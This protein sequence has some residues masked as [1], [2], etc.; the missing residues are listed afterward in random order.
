MADQEGVE[1]QESIVDVE[2]IDEKIPFTAPEESEMLAEHEALTIKLEEQASDTES[3]TESNGNSNDANTGKTGKGRSSNWR[4]G[5]KTKLGYRCTNYLKEDHKQPLFGVTFNYNFDENAED[6]LIF[7]TVGSNRASIYQ[8]KDKG[9][10]KLLQAYVDADPDE[11]FYTAA[12]S[13][14]L[15]SGEPILA[16]AGSRGIIRI[17]SAFTMQCS[18]HFLGHGSSVN[19]LKFHPL[20]P[21]LLLSVSKDYAL[22]LWNVRT[23]VCVLMFTGV[24]GHRD[25]VLSGDFDILGTRIISC[26]MDHSLKIWSL[27]EEKIKKT[28]EEAAVYNT[29]KSAKSFRTLQIHYPKFTTRDIHRNYVDCVR[30]LGDLVLSKSCENCIVCWKPKK[31]LEEVFAKPS[32]ETNAVTV[33]HK[34]EYA[35]CDIW[36]MRF[37]M[38]FRQKTLALGNQVGKIYTWYIDVTDLHEAKQKV[39]S[40]PKCTAAVRQTCFSKDGSILICVCDDGS[41]WRWDRAQ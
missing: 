26:G 23:E 4:K 18:K 32:D 27:D 20:D 13:F 12:W 17:I 21:E 16:I 41:I 25:E 2:T 11:N 31:T 3:M 34:F 14:V 36:F 7:A 33:L 15:E 1:N 35:Q 5:K 22:R 38:D 37:A 29:T 40:H 10:I 8:C 6:P 28:I 9:E 24:E 39:L 30:W 19:E